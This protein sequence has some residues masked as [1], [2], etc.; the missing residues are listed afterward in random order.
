M[1]KIYF[2]VL[3]TT[4]MF[5]GC[6]P[7]NGNSK[8][9]S[10]K[11]LDL[12]SYE[13]V[14]LSDP[15]MYSLAYMWNEERLAHDIYLNLNEL[16]PRA[17]FVNIATNGEVTHINLVRDI[18]EWYDINITN[19]V[20]YTDSFSQ[21]QLDSMPSGTYGIEEIQDLYDVLY[22]EGSTSL[23]EAVKVACKVEVVDV[24][25]LDAYI[26]DAAGNQALLDTFNILR[27][28]SY[29]HYWVFDGIL[30]EIGLEDGCC[31]AGL[32]YCKTTD[33]YPR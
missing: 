13:K 14:S 25:D 23:E 27:D 1:L 3:F 19:I 15:Q 8:A 5:L 24:D 16:Y 22:A 32:S 21:A 18:V 31:S 11:S 7:N 6:S 29:K 12:D 2:L 17:E 9:N 26:I 28:G 20:D 10:D 4:L 30:K 33:E